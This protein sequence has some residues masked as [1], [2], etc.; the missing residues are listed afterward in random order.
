MATNEELVD[1]IRRLVGKP[2]KSFHGSPL[3]Y[4]YDKLDPK[5]IGTGEKKQAYG[6]GHYSAGNPKTAAGYRRDLSYRKLREDFLRVLPDDALPEDVMD[7]V[8]NLD[9]FDPRQK[10]Y[11]TALNDDDWMGFDYPAQAIEHTIGRRA[12]NADYDP[13]FATEEAIKKLGTGYELE[14]AHPE[15]SLLDW[16]A[17]FN[18]QPESVRRV[19]EKFGIPVMESPDKWTGKGLYETLGRSPDI[20]RMLPEDAEFNGG[21]STKIKQQVSKALFEN[22]VPGVRYWDGM[23]RVL[24]PHQRQF[25]GY[26]SRNYVMFP[27]TEDQIRILRKYGVAAPITAGAAAGQ[28]E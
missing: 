11:L 23:S 21:Y 1:G 5:F 18:S 22:D 20:R 15:E 7:V 4:H 24:L 17:D 2:I 14:I 10:N 16:D 26:G 3:P 25:G 28:K 12:K 6:F 9:G 13:N 27:G 8:L 19:A